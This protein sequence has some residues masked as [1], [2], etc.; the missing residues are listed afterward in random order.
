MTIDRDTAQRK[1]ARDWFVE[2]NRCFVEEH[3]GCPCCGRRHCVFQAR[4][5][6]RTEYYCNECDF[7]AAYDEA[8]DNYAAN[9]GQETGQ[10]PLVLQ[11]MRERVS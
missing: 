8:S 10:A 9:P 6:H 4:W 1:A 7:S 2:A 11:G 5:G 3:Q